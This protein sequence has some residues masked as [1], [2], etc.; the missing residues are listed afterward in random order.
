MKGISLAYLK[1]DDG[2][3]KPRFINTNLIGALKISL[4]QRAFKHVVKYFSFQNHTK[5]GFPKQ[6][7]RT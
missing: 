7:Q 1:Q 2:T 3:L 5:G 4:V 6:L